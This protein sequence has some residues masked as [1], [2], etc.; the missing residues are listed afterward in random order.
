MRV[1]PTAKAL[2]AMASTNSIPRLRLERQ[3]QLWL[4]LL[5]LLAVF[6]AK[7]DQESLN[8]IEPIVKVRNA[9]QLRFFPSFFPSRLLVVCSGRHIWKYRSRES[10]ALLVHPRCVRLASSCNSLCSRRRDQLADWIRGTGSNLSRRRWR[11]PKLDLLSSCYPRVSS[12]RPSPSLHP[13]AKGRALAEEVKRMKID[14]AKKAKA[15]AKL[16]A[17]RA[18]EHEEITQTRKQLLEAR[19]EVCYIS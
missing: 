13:Y 1:Y 12:S 15:Y 2:V 10:I 4:S 5:S 18:A 16:E 14:A 8:E 17:E 7:S 19:N 11:F 9:A 3:P 6:A